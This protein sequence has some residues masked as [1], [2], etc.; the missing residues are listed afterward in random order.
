MW[1]WYTPAGAPWRV[2]LPQRTPELSVIGDYAFTYFPYYDRPASTNL[3]KLLASCKNAPKEPEEAAAVLNH[4]RRAA[5]QTAHAARLQKLIPGLRARRE[6]EPLPVWPKSAKASLYLTPVTYS[7]EPLPSLVLYDART[8]GRQRARTRMAA[9]RVN[10]TSPVKFV[11]AYLTPKDDGYLTEEKKNGD[12]TCKQSLPGTWEP[13]WTRISGCKCMGVIENNPVLSPGRTTMLMTCP[14][15]NPR[16]FWTWYTAGGEPVVFMETRPDKF[17]G[18]NLALADAYEWRPNAS[19]DDHLLNPPGKCKTATAGTMP[20]YF[21]HS[22]SETR[23]FSSQ[24]YRCHLPK[25]PK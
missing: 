15:V 1:A 24:C 23:E 16:V 10:P 22:D 19:I 8:A 3:S 11:D 18:T 13:S 4:H 5:S 17:V 7:S 12:L 25:A 6:N 2:M 21:F 20:Q 14:M 9:D